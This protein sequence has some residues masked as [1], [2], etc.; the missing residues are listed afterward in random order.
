MAGLVVLCFLGLTLIRYIE[1]YNGCLY[2]LSPDVALKELYS[3]RVPHPQ[4][5]FQL[6]MQKGIWHCLNSFQDFQ[7]DSNNI[8][9]L[10]A[11]PTLFKF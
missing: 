11:N 9:I 4:I 1:L 2:L 3:F 8:A 10:T 6:T 7:L 5:A